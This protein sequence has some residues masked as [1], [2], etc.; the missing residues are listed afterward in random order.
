MLLNFKISHFNIKQ[1][2]APRATS[3][4]R[5]HTNCTIHG[6][7]YG[8]QLVPQVKRSVPQKLLK[9][10]FSH[11]AQKL[12]L[13]HDNPSYHIPLTFYNS[14]KTQLLSRGNGTFLALKI[15]MDYIQF[16]RCFKYFP[17][18]NRRQKTTPSWD[19]SEWNPLQT[20]PRNNPFT[21][22]T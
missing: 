4:S 13:S 2:E 6:T 3:S 17:Q 15:H 5:K 8:T 14:T 18:G 7:E 20:Y 22:K 10:S 21:I 11:R 1:E 19:A 12:E 9:N 16:L